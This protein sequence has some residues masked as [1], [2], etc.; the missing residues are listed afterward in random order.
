MSSLF[1][2][3][4]SVYQCC[5]GLFLTLALI[6]HHLPMV[7]HWSFQCL[8]GRLEV[9]SWSCFMMVQKEY[10]IQRELGSGHRAGRP[11]CTKVSRMKVHGPLGGDRN[12]WTIGIVGRLDRCGLNQGWETLVGR[13]QIPKSW[14]MMPKS[15]NFAL[16]TLGVVEKEVR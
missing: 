11:G 5:Y 14:H 6:G 9:S 12:S 3:A 16:Q 8:F 4:S 7:S 10:S 1:I 2:A 15:L 13:S